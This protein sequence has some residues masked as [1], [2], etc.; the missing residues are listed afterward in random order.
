MS[1]DGFVRPCLATITA[2]TNLGIFF[3]LAH[4]YGRRWY[5]WVYQLPPYFEVVHAL[6][7]H[8]NTKGFIYYFFFLAVVVLGVLLPH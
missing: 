2:R 6:D 3:V 8:R 1:E 7:G 5:D 4:D